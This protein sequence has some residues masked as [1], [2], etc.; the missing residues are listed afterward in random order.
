MED[1]VF[2]EGLKMGGRQGVVFKGYSPGHVKDTPEENRCV[3][4]MTVVFPKKVERLN[5]A[6]QTLY[7][8]MSV[9]LYSCV[10]FLFVLSLWLLTYSDLIIHLYEML[11]S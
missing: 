8:Y 11:V 5:S 2:T 3:L 6:D 7:L 9:C 4:I 1:Q 10:F